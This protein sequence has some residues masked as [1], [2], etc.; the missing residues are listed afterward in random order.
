MAVLTIQTPAKINTKLH[1]LQ[2][3][4]DGYHELYMHMIPIDWHDFIEIKNNFNQ[5]L[6]LDQT[7]VEFPEDPEKNLVIQAARIFE[8]RRGVS[9]HYDFYLTKNIPIGAGLG[10]GSGNAAG[11]LTALNQLEN[12]FFSPTELFEMALGLGSDV[13]FFLN[14]QASIAT[15]RGEQLKPL[16]DFPLLH[17]ILI[18]PSFS[19]STATAYHGCL[20]RASLMK[21][22]QM[23]SIHT[24]VS[25]LVND[26]ERSLLPQ[27]P[28]LIEAKKA[29]MESGA[30]GALMSG[31]GSVVF[32]IYADS[33][34][35]QQA[36]E[37]P[38]FTRWKQV[39]A[40]KS[41]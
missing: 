39:Y 22:H 34:S 18:K 16:N 25:G 5:G 4:L 19:I 29:L 23:N 8:K 24:V 13:P 35:Q 9:L 38:V 1:I 41:L 28:E 40:A 21:E 3:R 33:Q 31:S 7:G 10:G 20:P 14:P 17:L 6:R 27:Y 2:K 32:G 12:Q 26:F 37:H 11:V 30:L 15:G 36:L